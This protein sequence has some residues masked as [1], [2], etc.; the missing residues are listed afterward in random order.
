VFEC[1]HQSTEQRPRTRLLA[2]R[3][4]D[5]SVGCARIVRPLCPTAADKRPGMLQQR[6]TERRHRAI[7]FASSH[8][9]TLF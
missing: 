9:E 4:N 3:L 7:L 6:E 5:G 1:G 2:P 8:K